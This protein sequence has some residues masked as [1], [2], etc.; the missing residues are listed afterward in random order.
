[1][2]CS[3]LLFSAQVAFGQSETDVKCGDIV[4]AEFTQNAEEHIYLLPMKPKEIFE[5]AVEP[6]GE[7]LQTVLGIYGPSGLRVAVSGEKQFGVIALVSQTPKLASG[8]LGASGVYKIRITNTGIDIR[9]NSKNITSDKLWTREDF[10]GVGVYSLFI[11]CIQANGTV[12]EPGEDAIATDQ[13]PATSEQTNTQIELT[14]KPASEAPLSI[15]EVGKNYEIFFGSQNMIV[16]ILEIG[17][18]G[19]TK[20]E[21]D[22]RI[23]WLNTHQIALIIP[24][25]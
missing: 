9:S 11:R 15:L 8:V 10:G 5:V 6:A 20:V 21:V 19:W 24:S 2:I 16:K 13:L 3:T 22:G 1:M 7:D 23:G 25:N 17:N 12:I 14:E 18:D 4:D